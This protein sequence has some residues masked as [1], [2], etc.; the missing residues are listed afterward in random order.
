MTLG[1]L[2]K[3]AK[4][5]DRSIREYGRDS[6]VD[7]TVISKIISNKYIPK[8]ATI[9]KKLTSIEA[10]PRGGI[11]YKDLIEA[12][13][14]EASFKEGIL[15]GMGAAEMALSA[16]GGLPAA[17]VGVT[18]MSGTASFLNGLSSSKSKGDIERLEKTTKEI[19]QFRALANGLLL[20]R[21]STN[22]VSVKIVD[23]KYID[24]LE[25]EFDVCVEVSG[26]DINEYLLRYVYIAKEHEGNSFIVENT[27]KRMLDGL[28]FL[29]PDRRRKIVMVFNN[30]DSYNSLSKY[31]NKLSLKGNLSSVLIDDKNIRI[32][33]EDELA[34]YDSL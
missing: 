9:Y 14:D 26:D 22:G 25:N 23:S 31:R 30:E 19:R 5:E 10:S 3:K 20:D 4:G 27:P 8:R 12:A 16:V 1:D 6:G 29:K 13:K 28:L 21:L 2:V 24:I 15:M 33:A 17:L 11:T 7:P 34:S 18:A 32:Q